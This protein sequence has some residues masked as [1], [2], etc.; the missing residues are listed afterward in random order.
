MY[1][2]LRFIVLIFALD[3]PSST[4]SDIFCCY[5]SRSSSFRWF[6]IPFDVCQGKIC[7]FIVCG[8][9]DQ[10]VVF[11]IVISLPFILF[12]L[13][14][15]GKTNINKISNK[16]TSRSTLNTHAAASVLVSQ[17]NQIRFCSSFGFGAC[18][19]YFS[20]TH[21]PLV[22]VQPKITLQ[23]LFIL[24]SRVVEVCKPTE[25]LPLIHFKCS[26]RSADKNLPTKDHTQSI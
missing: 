18:V 2:L 3:P 9:Q 19:C 12:V 20:L 8:W 5:R 26:T 15:N 25:I 7:I 22:F 16:S 21:N 6:P 17:M 24:V 10:R 4:K 1:G 13:L 11:F 23:Q 14:S